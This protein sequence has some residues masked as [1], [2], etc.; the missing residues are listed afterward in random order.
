MS[1]FSSFFWITILVS[2]LSVLPSAFAGPACVRRDQQSSN[3]ASICAGKWG[4]PGKAMGKDPWGV[5]PT[6]SSDKTTSTPKPYKAA[7]SPSPSSTPEPSPSPKTSTPAPAATAASSDTSASDIDQYLSAHNSVRSQHGATALTWS[8]SLAAAAQK[9]ADGCQFVHSGGKLGP[10]GGTLQP[11]S[12]I[13]PPIVYHFQRTWLPVLGVTT[14][15][16]LL[17]NRGQ[18]KSVSIK[19]NRLDRYPKLTSLISIA[20]YNSGNPQPSHFTQVVWKGTTQ[21]GCAVQKCNGIFDASF[22]VSC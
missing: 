9:W 14:T 11:P 12:V 15:S 3:C 16:P 21:V 4:L 13:R 19:T 10:F 1:R 8:N 20:Q 17:S 7:P 22:G 6:S 5:V 2:F 18:M